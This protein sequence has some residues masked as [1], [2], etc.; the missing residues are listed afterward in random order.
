MSGDLNA[1]SIELRA[2]ELLRYSDISYNEETAFKYNLVPQTLIL[3]VYEDIF[4]PTLYVDLTVKDTVNILEGFGK[5][6]TGSQGELVELIGEGIKGDEHILVDFKDPRAVPGTNDHDK[7]IRSF[8][9]AVIGTMN[10]NPLPNQKGAT[11]TLRG[12]S[13]QHLINTQKFVSKTYVDKYP[14]E[15]IIDILTSED[16]LGLKLG[17]DI[18]PVTA[19]IYTDADGVFPYKPG[20]SFTGI[21]EKMTI[22]IPRLKPLQA[23]DMVRQRAVSQ[24][25]RG[26]PYVFYRDKWGYTFGTI[27]GVIA[28]YGNVASKT[29]TIGTAINTEDITDEAKDNNIEILKVVNYQDTFT[30][31]SGGVANT[32]VKSFN[33]TSKAFKKI[34]NVLS[35]DQAPLTDKDDELPYS[36]SLRAKFNKASKELFVPTT[37]DL[38]TGIVDS[39]GFKNAIGALLNETIVH[40]FVTG[41]TG[42]FV[43]NIVELK[44]PDNKPTSDQGDDK[45]L[46]GN[47]IVAK[48]RHMISGNE[49]KQSMELIK[50]GANL[51]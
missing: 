42:V 36:D 21:S 24:M 38:G 1:S 41:D 16:Y 35:K 12:I 22:T 50:I 7:R 45:L 44:F 23:I 28:S 20:T 49:Y 46:A 27:K 4:A 31:A 3:N 5:Y 2:L 6:R 13:E 8:Y 39:I 9:L 37:H 14:E 43:G 33:F 10:K 40:V 32:V 34:E 17:Q 19:E 11:Y 25:Y 15:I 18:D 48:I 47:Y 30:K 26:S 29:Y 51:T